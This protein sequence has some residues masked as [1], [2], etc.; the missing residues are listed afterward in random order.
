LDNAEYAKHA[1]A[2]LEPSV[3]LRIHPVGRRPFAGDYKQSDYGKVILP[4]YFG[5]W[6]CV[7]LLENS[8]SL[9]E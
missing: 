5:Q 9:P 4:P 7:G 2:S 1:G 3:P 8:R 6:S